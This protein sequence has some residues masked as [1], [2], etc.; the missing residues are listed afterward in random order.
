MIITR[1]P[2]DNF[3]LNDFLKRSSYRAFCFIEAQVVISDNTSVTFEHFLFFSSSNILFFVIT[4]FLLA[5]TLPMTSEA[6]AVAT[7]MTCNTKEAKSF[8]LRHSCLD[9]FVISERNRVLAQADGLDQY[10]SRGKKSS[11]DLKR[12]KILH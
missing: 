11:S 9:G 1:Q 5:S 4:V 6:R 12:A 8:W 10:D 3:I 2:H 7:K